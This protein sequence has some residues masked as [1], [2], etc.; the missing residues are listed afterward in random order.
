MRFAFQISLSSY[1]IQQLARKSH[2]NTW[3]NYIQTMLKGSKQLA[4]IAYYLVFE[5]KRLMEALKV[6]KKSG[7]EINS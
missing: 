6:V 1:V 4:V 7:I 2:L 3:N 5:N